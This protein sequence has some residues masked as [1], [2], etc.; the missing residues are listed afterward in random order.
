MCFLPTNQW[1][2]PF[3]DFYSLLFGFLALHPYSSLGVNADGSVTSFLLILE[4]S[5]LHVC[6]WQGS[7]VSV[8]DLWGIMTSV[9]SPMARS[10]PTVLPPHHLAGSSFWSRRRN[11]YPGVPWMQL[12][13]SVLYPLSC[14]REVSTGMTKHV[15]LVLW[16]AARINFTD[17]LVHLTSSRSIHPSFHPSTHSSYLC[18]VCSVS[19]NENTLKSLFL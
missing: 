3:R 12:C 14:N 10:T 5:W 8:A 15:G 2:H 13:V 7:E 17:L 4:R 18:P 16:S 19:S 1:K 11:V 9:E 6:N